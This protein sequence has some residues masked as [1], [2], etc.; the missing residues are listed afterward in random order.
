MFISLS[1]QH[2]IEII[3]NT[4]LSLL[5]G[6]ICRSLPLKKKSYK[7]LKNS[8]KHSI[9][10]HDLPWQHLNMHTLLYIANTPAKGSF[11]SVIRT[12]ETQTF[13]SFRNH[14]QSRLPVWMVFMP[15]SATYQ[16]IWEH[17]TS[18]QQPKYSKFRAYSA[19]RQTRECYFHL[20]F[21]FQCKKILKKPPP[22]CFFFS[23]MHFFVGWSHLDQDAIL[24]LASWLELPLKQIIHTMKSSRHLQLH[25]ISFFNFWSFICCLVL[26]KAW[27]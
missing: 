27:E 11:Y 2:D 22:F 18:Q 7:K 5:W 14:A 25:L 23:C 26:C 21:K 8:W 13:L 19:K 17:S 24:L 20:L 4:K 9:L 12:P 15:V 3:N 6:N 10:V 16:K 1:L